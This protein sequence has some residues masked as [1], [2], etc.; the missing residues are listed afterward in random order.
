LA[1]WGAYIFELVFE[2]NLL[3][4]GDPIFS[5]G[6]CAKALFQNNVPFLG[7]ERHSHCI[8][9]IFT[10]CKTFSR[11]SSEN[12]TIFAGILLS[13]SLTELILLIGFRKNKKAAGG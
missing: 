1:I 8:G 9:N 4:D 13:A 6:R 2:L 12:L 7:T 5:Y 3:G 11:A 10:P